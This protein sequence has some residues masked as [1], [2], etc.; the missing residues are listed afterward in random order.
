MSSQA[1]RERLISLIKQHQLD[2]GQSK[3]SITKLSDAAGISRQAFNR[4]Y[5]DLKDYCTGKLSIARL[6]V[7]D[8]ASL[9]ELI[10]NKEER[11][12]SLEKELNSIRTTHKAELEA[13]VD[14]YLSTL[15]NNDIISFEAGQLAATLTSQGNHNAFLNKRVTELKVQNAKL[16]MD[17][18]GASSNDS[19]HTTEKSDKNFIVFDL[20]LSTAKK[21]FLVSKSFNDYED[22]KYSAISKIEDS[23][24]KLPNPE[25]LDVLFFQEKYISDFNLFCKGA[26]PAKGRTLI[27]VRLPLYSQEELKLL[28]KNLAPI[29][30]FSIY[31]P[32]SP[33]NAVISAKRQFSFRDIPLE[34]IKLADTARTPLPVWGFESIHINKVKQGD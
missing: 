20:D 11:I 15:M 33:S 25:N 10:E 12:S 19:P 8:N 18:V 6:L 9:H 16:T 27:V 1:T 13:V 29:N 34:E 5:G 17:L 7:D 14:N 3:L 21:A 23:I 22:A 24:K 4:Y 2:N 32:Y 28:M 30:S 26:L 31:V